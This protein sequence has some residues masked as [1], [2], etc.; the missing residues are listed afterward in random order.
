MNLAGTEAED[1]G[2]AGRAAWR[3]AAALLLVLGALLPAFASASAASVAVSAFV[4]PRAWLTIET[5]PANLTITEADIRRGF[6]DLPGASRIRVRTNSSAG[7][8]LSFELESECVTGVVL[9]GAGD[10]IQLTGSGGLVPRPYPGPAAAVSELGYRFL[11]SPGA[12]PGTHPW[13]VA[14]SAIPR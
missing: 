8:L 6:V 1:T 10:R 11:I 4:A 12:R 13:P 2:R 9:D 3:P 7:Y 5:Q 14:L